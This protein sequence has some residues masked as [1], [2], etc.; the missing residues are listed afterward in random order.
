MVRRHDAG[1]GTAIL[2]FM[3][4]TD[5]EKPWEPLR[6]E[7]PL[8]AMRPVRCEAAICVGEGVI[9]TSDASATSPQRCPCFTQVP[10]PTPLSFYAALQPGDV[11]DYFTDDTDSWMPARG[12]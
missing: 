7:H 6:E 9:I 5:D 10:P 4:L 11:V 1:R 12:E 3:G 2:E 8:C